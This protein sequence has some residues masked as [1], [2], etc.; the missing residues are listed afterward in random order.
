[1]DHNIMITARLVAV[2]VCAFAAVAAAPIQIVGTLTDAGGNALTGEITV[3]EEGA[4]LT[5]STYPVDDTG[6]FKLSADARGDVVVMA[7]S[8]HRPPDERHIPAGSTGPVMIRFALPN[9][10]DLT[11]RVVDAGGVGIPDAVVQVRYHEPGKAIRRAAFDAFATTDGDGMFLL[12]NVGVDVSFVVDVLAP[13]YLPKSSKRFKRSADDTKLDN[14]VLE[15]RGG[16]VH[17]EVTD[18][19]RSPVGGAQVHLIADPAGYA[20]AERGSLVHGRVYHQSETTSGFGNVRF[21]RVPSGRIRI[22]LYD[23]SGKLHTSDASVAEGQS[24]RLT[25]SLP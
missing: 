1:M 12:R 20:P 9:G 14:V 22:G 11:G 3:F 21:T 16:T 18:G 13:G 10:Q 24:L 15:D 2:H 23:D 7:T 5:V 19:A 25:M 17:V 8:D 4:E 6:T